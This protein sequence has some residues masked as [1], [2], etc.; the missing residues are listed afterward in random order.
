MEGSHECERFTN[1][2]LEQDL[3]LNWKLKFRQ[4]IQIVALF[5]CSQTHRGNHPNPSKKTN[6]QKNKAKRFPSTFLSFITSGPPS[7]W[8]LSSKV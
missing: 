6:H 1:T 3:S 8:S 7:S 2:A 5:E 4:A